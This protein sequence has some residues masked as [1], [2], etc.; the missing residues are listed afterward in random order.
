MIMVI[1]VQKPLE[2]FKIFTSEIFSPV[3]C[4]FYKYSKF[5]NI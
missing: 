4:R 5:E 1:H 3:A 2:S